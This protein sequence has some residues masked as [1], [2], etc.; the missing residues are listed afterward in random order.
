MKKWQPFGIGGVPFVRSL[1]RD[2]SCGL[3]TKEVEVF[4]AA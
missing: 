3:T 4:G 2:N 1:Q